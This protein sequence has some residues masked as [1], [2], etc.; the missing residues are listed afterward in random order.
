MR[1]EFA[2]N[3]AARGLLVRQPM[4]PKRYIWIAIGAVI[5]LLLLS[6]LLQSG[7]V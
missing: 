1:N 7:L 6:V 2:E 5:V 3:S 4:I